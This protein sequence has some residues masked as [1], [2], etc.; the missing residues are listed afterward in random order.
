MTVYDI[1]GEH[2]SR[3]RVRITKKVGKAH[4]WKRIVIVERAFVELDHDLDDVLVIGDLSW[5]MDEAIQVNLSSMKRVDTALVRGKKRRPADAGARITCEE[6][7]TL[8]VPK[9]RPVFCTL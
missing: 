5:Q 3:V 1:S 7:L 8:I 4:G 9:F 6:H 2:V